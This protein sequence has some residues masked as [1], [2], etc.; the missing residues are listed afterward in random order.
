MSILLQAERLIAGTVESNAPVIFDSTVIS[1]GNIS[2]DSATGVITIQEPG[3]YE[4][5]WWVAVQSSASAAGAGFALASSQGDTIIGNL[6]IKTGEVVGVGIIEVTAAPIT[7]ALR[8]SSSATTYYSATVPVKASLAVIAIADTGT[9]GPTGPTGAAGD[10]GPTGPTGPTGAVGTMA[11]STQCFAIRQLANLLEQITVLYPATTMTL[12]VDQLATLSGVAVEVYT[13]P[14]ADGPG[15]LIIQSGSDYG[16]VSLSRIAAIYLGAGSVYDP[17]ITYL[18]PPDPYAPGC[19]TDYIL[20]VQSSM[21]VG[22]QI[23]F[24]AATNTTGSGGVYINEP[25]ILVLSDGA[26]NTPVFLFTP[27]IRYLVKDSLPSARTSGTG[28]PIKE[29]TIQNRSIQLDP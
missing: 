24:G 8:S 21:S 5:D 9:T 10:T 25:G 1:A 13:A 18:P 26:G 14:G 3:R 19:D 20:A 4:F 23:S 17:S 27:Q 11:D 28:K 6:P 22:D 15:L 29:V 12:F 2:Y 7:V 16:Y